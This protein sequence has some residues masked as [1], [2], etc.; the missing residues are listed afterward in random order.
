MSDAARA[1]LVAVRAAQ[2][3]ARERARRE[4]VRTRAWCGA[5]VGVI[6]L[7]VILVGP[8]VGRRDRAAVAAEPPAP[9]PV[10]L[11]VPAA[12]STVAAPA[13]EPPVAP[14]PSPAAAPADEH[15]VVVAAAAVAP[16]TKLVPQT[17]D[18]TVTFGQRRWRMAAET[19]ARAFE[20]RPN[21]AG[22]A[23]TVAHAHHARGRYA[24]AGEWARRSI[25]LDAR[26]AEAF[27][28][29]AHA[30]TRA[31]NASAAADAYR[32]YLALAPRGWHSAE[33]RAALRGRS[34]AASSDANGGSF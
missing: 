32:K 29:L 34:E 15:P 25:A 24:E 7:G 3:A 28:I 2:E 11:A 1:S 9:A 18:C 16:D 26:Y 27:V 23:L 31:G 13:T 20:S 4:T 33:A 17:G 19:C 5:I 6:A 10:A 22:L 21:D 14:V 12:S 30:E 8:R